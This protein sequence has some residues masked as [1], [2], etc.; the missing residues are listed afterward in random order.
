MA[1]TKAQIRSLARK[2]TADTDA[3][4]PFWSDSDVNLLIDNWQ[5]DMASYLRW[6]RATS[7][8]ISLVAGQDDYDLP[9]DWLMTIKVIIYD[10]SGYEAKLTYKSEDE[11]SDIDPNWRNSTDYSTPKYYFIGGDITPGST[12]ARKLFVYPAPSS[13]DTGKYL[14]QKYVK[15]PASITNDTDIPVFPSYTHM[16]AV[17][18]LAWQMNLPLD[19]NKADMYKRLYERERLRLCGEVKKDS[20]DN[21]YIT[22]R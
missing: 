12:L 9:T 5:S 11:I 7:T 3:N 21:S 6:P 15:V 4:N 16:L 14:L 1:L 19:V 22:I 20:E 17:Y 8:P 18:Y 2:F 13:I 10:N